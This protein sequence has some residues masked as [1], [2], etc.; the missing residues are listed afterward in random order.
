MGAHFTQS[1]ED[2]FPPGVRFPAGQLQSGPEELEH[3][4]W[5]TGLSIKSSTFK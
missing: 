1:I 4:G 3:P 5:M 2:F